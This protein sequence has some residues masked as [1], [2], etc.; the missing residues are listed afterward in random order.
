[1][2][3][4]WWAVEGAFTFFCGH[5]QAL[6]GCDFQVCPRL[7]TMHRRWQEQVAS[8]LLLGLP[9]LYTGLY[10]LDRNVISLSFKLHERSYNMVHSC[11][12]LRTCHVHS[13][14]KCN[15]RRSADL[16]R[17]PVI[18]SIATSRRDLTGPN[19]PLRSLFSMVLMC[20][21]YK[22]LHRS[23]GL[24]ERVTRRESSLLRENLTEGTTH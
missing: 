15:L 7:I 23:L 13:T 11:R 20:H 19:S 12:I 22:I 14:R 17:R 5:F 3:S 24:T 9:R 6:R 10:H 8:F 1:M 21:F 18:L 2:C 16:A 4:S